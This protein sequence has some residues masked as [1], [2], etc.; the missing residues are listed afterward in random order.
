MSNL[1]P[2][3]IPETCFS[4]K[5]SGYSFLLVCAFIYL[6]L[7]SY[8]S[9][10][11]TGFQLKERHTII[12]LFLTQKLTQNNPR[13]KRTL[14]IFFQSSQLKMTS[15]RLSNKNCFRLCSVSFYSYVF[16]LS[17]IFVVL[18]LAFQTVNSFDFLLW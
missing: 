6:L 11:N 5:C 17:H 10:L 3:V 16:V 8:T 12:F 13:K 15:E 1:F 2:T 14:Y 18:S 9:V 4:W 7:F